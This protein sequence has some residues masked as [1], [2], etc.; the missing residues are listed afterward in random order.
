MD[1]PVGK[2]EPRLENARRGTCRTS[3][4]F[5][6]PPFPPT[7]RTGIGHA[8]PHRVR[9]FWRPVFRSACRMMRTFQRPR[10]LPSPLGPPQCCHSPSPGHGRTSDRCSF[11]LTIEVRSRAAPRVQVCQLTTHPCRYVMT[12]AFD[13]CVPRSRT[14]LRLMRPPCSGA[15]LRLLLCRIHDLAASAGTV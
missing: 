14:P 3:H 11:S 10:W 8:R 15:L 4:L 7:M 5:S 9:A 2:R 1:S 6:P 12:P 13:N